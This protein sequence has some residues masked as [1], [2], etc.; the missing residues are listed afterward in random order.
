MWRGG[1][2]RC[3]GVGLEVW[4]VGAEMWGGVGLRGGKGW[5]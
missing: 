5:G 3:G 4:R 1:V 2:E